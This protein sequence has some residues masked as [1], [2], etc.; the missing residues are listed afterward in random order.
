LKKD[1]GFRWN[2]AQE[3]SFQGLIRAT[4]TAPALLLPDPNLPYVVT[5]DA[6]GY[7]IGASLM[8]DHGKG[9]Q[10][11]AFMSKKLTPAELK[12]MN[13]ERELLALFKAP[14]LSIR[15]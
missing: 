8:Q 6:C 14:P 3:E 12:Y 15:Q 10:P 5:A 4:T 2:A 7:G 1:S 11:V 13:N 9:L